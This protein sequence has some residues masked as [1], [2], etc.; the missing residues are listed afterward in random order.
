M[1][2]RGEDAIILKLTSQWDVKESIEDKLGLGWAGKGSGTCRCG[3]TRVL[4]SRT[5]GKGFGGSIV[6]LYCSIQNI[7]LAR[8]SSHSSPPLTRDVK[9][10]F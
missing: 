4:L 5:S 9:Q 6:G 2:L 3:V 10:G 7:I 1:N 8:N